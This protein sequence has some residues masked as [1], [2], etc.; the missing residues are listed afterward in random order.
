M[1][2]TH[3]NKDGSR[4]TERL[5]STAMV[6][7]IA[8]NLSTAI[9]PVVDGIIVGT[10]YSVDDV[11][12]I[13]LTS[14]L[15]V[16][17]RTVAASII[18]KGAHVIAS[19]R[20]GAGDKEAANRVFSLSV[21][22]SLFSAAVLALL[23]IVFSEQ[24]A[25]FVGA[26][27]GLARLMTPASDYLR[28][29]CVGLP[30]FAAT[31]VLTPFLQMDGDYNRVTFSSVVMTI[32]D[33]LAD[34]YVVKI[35]HG[36]LF[37][38]GLATAVGYFASFLVVISHFIFKK[39]IFRF[40][41]KRIRWS[42]SRDI[43][44]NG[45]STG[46]VKLSNTFSGILINQMMAVSFSAEVIAAF[47]V[48]NQI[49]KFCFSLWLGAANTL[50]SFSSMFFGEED[51]KALQDVQMVALRKGLALTC[52]AAAAIFLFA[53]P[54]SGVFLRNANGAA[55]GMAAES[56]RF[57]A[58]SMPLNVF[59]YCFQQYLIG[60]GRKLFSCVYSFI[61]DFAIPVP[62]TFL[63]LAALGYRGALIA[64]P[65]INIAVI[66]A[67]VL[68]I[69]RQRGTGFREKMLLLPENFGAET[70]HE[71][72][73]EGDSMFDVIGVSRIAIAFILENG[74]SKHDANIVSLAIEELAGNIVQHGFTDGRPHFVQIR[75]LAKD[76]ELILRLR[77]DCRPFDPVDRYR[78]QL[79]F[80]PDPEKGIAIKMMMRL[81]REIRYTG[82]YG[83]NN[84]II[85][86]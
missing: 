83:M 42:E 47:G 67:A 59:I 70:A 73:M 9:G 22:L 8:S 62:M 31:T 78:T 10:C 86:I 64:K 71:L 54:L 72:F 34:L 58:L 53:G 37:Q 29:Y 79:Q 2:T 49:F 63:L 65:V 4:I 11:A 35:L 55:K 75:I 76:G 41:P 15:L 46:V 84:L 57:L 40:K 13:G 14:F 80:E 3:K 26:R 24:L 77:D 61:L 36:G 21:I 39:S 50:M 32:A 44:A 56:I 20:I 7:Y 5:F 38:I 45:M 16:G 30:F 60:V 68:Y 12:A 81:V 69:L 25:V 66:L 6:A 33:I 1:F 19:S 23:S 52:S 18:A 17:Y 85:R 51:K 82:L 27:K 28:G 48:G 43:L 74:F